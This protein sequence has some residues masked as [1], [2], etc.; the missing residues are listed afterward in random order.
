MFFAPIL[1]LIHAIYRRYFRLNVN[2]MLMRKRILC[3]IGLT[4]S[5][6][7][8]F[9]ACQDTD[10]TP[11]FIQIDIEDVN[12]AVDVSSFNEDHG[13]NYDSEQLES[14]T[15]HTFSHVNVYVNG[16]NLGCWQLPCKVPVLDLKDEDSSEV[17]ILPCFKKT[18][19][20]NTIQGYP[21][22]NVLRQKVLLKRGAVYDVSDCPI[23][24]KYSSYAMFPYME[25]FTNSSSFMPTDS[26][27]SVLSFQPTM[28]EGRTVG[29]ICLNDANGLDFDVTS[30]DITLPVR[31][32]Y[33]FLEVTYKTESS[34][35]LGMKISTAPYP[36]TVYQIGGMY[37]TD[38]EWK[39]IY[40]DLSQ[41]IS[42]YH[43][44]SGNVTIGNLVLT[45]IGEE[46]R[47]TN[48]YIDNIKVIYEPS[49]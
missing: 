27:H 23:V 6:L 25:T 40:F 34:M 45:G 30:V 26:T 38:G 4:I 36:N 29:A 24:Y 18:G 12:G 22:F 21:F 39:T 1:L 8:L 20:N 3:F 37:A 42:G 11:A 48:F 15:Q 9:S 19:M 28:V 31:N 43:N 5:L 44:A 49:A 32:Y 46:G 33:V 47:N 7:F 35:G 14:L 2:F 41:M 13:L 17:I 16:K 10:L